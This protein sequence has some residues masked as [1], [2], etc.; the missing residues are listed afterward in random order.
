MR[1]FL[2][3]KIVKW[4]PGESAIGVKNISLSEDF[5]SDHFPRRP[6]MPGVLILEGMAQLSGVLLEET[7]KLK[8]GVSSKAIVTIIDKTKFKQMS[9]PGDQLEYHSEVIA[10]NELGGKTKCTAYCEGNMITETTFTF[11]FRNIDDQDLY[12]DRTKLLNLWLE[13]VKT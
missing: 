4:K 11:G 12:R 7:L 10:L 13:G 8:E 9:K 5:F 1:F 3:D 6:I 2:I